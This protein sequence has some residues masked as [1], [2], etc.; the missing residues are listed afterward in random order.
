MH[1]AMAMGNPGMC[2]RQQSGTALL[3]GK[4][5]PNHAPLVVADTTRAGSAIVAGIPAAATGILRATHVDNLVSQPTL[6]VPVPTVDCHVQNAR[7][8]TFTAR[9]PAQATFR[10]YT[11]TF[12][13]NLWP[14]TRNAGQ[15]RHWYV[16]KHANNHQKGEVA[17]A[18]SD[19][20]SHHR[21]A[22]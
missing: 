11:L 15:L 7:Y 22:H 5:A 10:S 19:V 16:P 21:F 3:R 17:I 1:V 2:A 14:Q 9:K 18:I 20:V 8:R 6:H 12:A 13:V 4:L